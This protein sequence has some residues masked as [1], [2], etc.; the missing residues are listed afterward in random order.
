M[1][2]KHLRRAPYRPRLEL[3]AFL[4]GLALFGVGIGITAAGAAASFTYGWDQERAVIKF[5]H[6]GRKIRFVLPL[7]DRSAREFTHTPG[8]GNRRSDAD[9]YKA[10]EQ[11][12]RQRLR[13]RHK[14]Q[15]RSR[16]GWHHN[17]RG[18]VQGA[19]RAAGW[20]H[21]RS[22][23]TS[24]DCQGVRGQHHAVAARP[25][26]GGELIVRRSPIQRR[27]PLRPLWIRKPTRQQKGWARAVAEVR[28][29]SGDRCEIRSPICTY[30]GTQLTTFSIAR[31]E[32]RQTRRYSSEPARPVT[33]TSATTWPRR[34]S[35]AG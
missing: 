32:A 25:R 1:K 3:A 27:T 24:S 4:L 26:D 7:P 34:M 5:H 2:A 33:P 23:G 14:S 12:C 18:R 17:V 20:L 22:L 11:A 15:A 21:F 19:H 30:V 9:A 8:R 10:W 16:R 6:Q 35:G 29:R 31:R 13:A 28:K